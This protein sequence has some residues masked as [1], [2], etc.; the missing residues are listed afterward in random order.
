M[1]KEYAFKT[2]NIR[3]FIFIY[4]LIQR[5]NKYALTMLH[6]SKGVGHIMV[7]S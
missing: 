6:F 4:L 3:I 7:I 5:L 1:L 2:T